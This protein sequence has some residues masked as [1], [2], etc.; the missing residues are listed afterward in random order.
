MHTKEYDMKGIVLAGGSGSRLYP[1]S[2]AVNKHLLPVGRYPMIYYPIYK[3]KEAGIEE[4][5][6]VTGKE[7]AGSIAGFLGSGQE[8]GL[9][10]TYG[11]QD[12]PGGIAHALSL[13]EG[14]V[15][16]NRCVVILGDNIFEDSLSEYVAQFKTQKEGAMV[17]LSWVVHPQRYG[18][19]ELEGVRIINI[20]EK[21]L[22]PKTN[23]CVTGIY[24]FDSEVFKIIKSLKPSDRGELEITDVNNEYIKRGKMKS[25]IL[26]GWWIDAGTFESLAEANRLADDLIINCIQEEAEYPNE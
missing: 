10:F 9:M 13:A 19:A 5:F 4:I 1:L 26:K 22:A 12:K 17:L 2:K 20:E 11:I 15:G 18:I 16:D 25:E 14:F 8:L 7:H 23:Y 3:L 6:I 24:M 21:P